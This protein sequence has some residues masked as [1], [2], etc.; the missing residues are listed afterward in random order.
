M[1]RREV[2]DELLV[3]QHTHTQTYKCQT[4]VYPRTRASFLSV[5]LGPAEITSL[6]N[7]AQAKTPR[8]R[9]HDG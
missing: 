1:E 9:S 7:S 6:D 2:N 8:K 5:F 4:T 3:L